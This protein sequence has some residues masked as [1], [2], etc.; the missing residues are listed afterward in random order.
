MFNLQL[1]PIVS[2]CVDKNLL[3]QNLATKQVFPAPEFP[4]ISIL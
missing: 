3:S 1:I 2:M 4:N